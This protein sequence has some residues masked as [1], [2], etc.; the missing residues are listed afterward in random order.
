MS[1]TMLDQIMFR[2][3]DTP[4]KPAETPKEQES[5]AASPVEFNSSGDATVSGVVLTLAVFYVIIYLM[6]LFMRDNVKEVITISAE[7]FI[8]IIVLIGGGV[9]LYAG[10]NTEIASSA[11][12][13]VLTFWF[14]RRQNESQAKLLNEAQQQQANTP[15][16]VVATKKEE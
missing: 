12:A 16:V 11:I 15:T 9:L 6:V 1:S 4:A 7:F 3:I 2:G 13:T 8:S 14:V 10:N 5:F